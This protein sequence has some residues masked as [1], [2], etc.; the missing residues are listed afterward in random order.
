[1]NGKGNNMLSFF[2]LFCK[3]NS[4]FSSLSLSLS[5]YIYIYILKGREQATG[6]PHPGHALLVN[7]IMGE[8]S[9]THATQVSYDWI[10]FYKRCWD[11]LQIGYGDNLD[12]YNQRPFAYSQ[13]CV[14][15]CYQM[16]WKFVI[17]VMK[18]PRGIE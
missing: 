3:P 18:L 13:C 7:N 16:Y 14:K 17:S 1:M 9:R 8:E 15:L 2:L 12:C 4:F 11:M 5:L 10:G 6:R